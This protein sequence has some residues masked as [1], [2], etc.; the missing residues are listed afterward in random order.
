MKKAIQTLSM[1]LLIMGSVYAWFLTA[2]GAIW[3]ASKEYIDIQ[4]ALFALPVAGVG[5]VGCILSGVLRERWA[6]HKKHHD[7]APRLVVNNTKKKESTGEENSTDVLSDRS[8]K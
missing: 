7:R 3:V 8:L 6:F 1:L 4:V 2:T 5:A